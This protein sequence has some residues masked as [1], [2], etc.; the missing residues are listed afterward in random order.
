MASQHSKTVRRWRRAILIAVVAVL[1]LAALEA[2]HRGWLIVRGRPYRA[3]QARLG[4]TELLA[5]M[6]DIVPGEAHPS[7][8]GEREIE[9]QWSLH[10]FFGFQYAS[11]LDQEIGAAEQQPAEADYEI[12]IVGGSVAAQIFRLGGATLTQMLEADPRMAGKKVRLLNGA[13]GAYKQPQ[14]MI[15]LAYLLSLGLRPDAVIN[16]DGFNEV[17]NSNDNAH[18]AVHPV[19]PSWFHWQ[20]LARRTVDPEALELILAV[21]EARAAASDFTDLVLD[22][23][24]YYSSLGG[25]LT[26]ARLRHLREEWYAA[27]ERY[28]QYL[29]RHS[30]ELGVRSPPFKKEGALD[31]TVQ[32]WEEGSLLI[33]SICDGR[34][35][36]YLHVLQPTLHDPG[37]KPLTEVEV[38]RGA[39]RPEWVEG[40]RSGY[41]LL[42]E[43]GERLRERGVPFLDASMVFA[44]ETEP[45]YV[46]SCHYDEQGCRTVAGR[47]AVAFLECMGG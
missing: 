24:L 1:S 44:G 31:A 6:T 16:V 36:R 42:R 17:A 30:T 10:P 7:R 28:L 37:S 13:A 46:D 9:Q 47:I 3:S 39:A 11:F 4:L 5:G 40:V 41:P 25:E 35:M 32:I 18:H 33:K 45:V 8:P 21:R 38:R 20:H 19:Y 23:R 14:Q 27:H 22:S 43:G 12:L 26:L 29:T 15:V 34:S 2:L